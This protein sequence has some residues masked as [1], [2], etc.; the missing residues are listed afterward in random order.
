MLGRR[1]FVQLAVPE[2]VIEELLASRLKALMEKANPEREWT[3]DNHAGF[4]QRF[5][6]Q[7]EMVG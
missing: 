4:C 1:Y 7:L 6:E 2:A 3:L 5:R